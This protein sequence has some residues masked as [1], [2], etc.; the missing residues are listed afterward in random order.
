MKKGVKILIGLLVIGL[1]A[2][3]LYAAFGRKKPV[4]EEDV[5]PAVAVSSPAIRDITLYHRLWKQLS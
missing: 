2:G 4:E 1:A 5:R 3:G